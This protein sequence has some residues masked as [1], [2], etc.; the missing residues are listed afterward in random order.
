MYFQKSNESVSFEVI[1]YLSVM[2]VQENE[3]IKEDQRDRQ[4]TVWN[5]SVH[6]HTCTFAQWHSQ[7]NI[8][9]AS[10]FYQLTHTKSH[11]LI[12][13]GTLKKTSL[14]LVVLSTCQKYLNTSDKSPMYKAIYRF[15]R[16]G[17]I[18]LLMRAASIARAIWRRLGPGLFG[19]CE[20][21]SSR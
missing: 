3:V 12:I 13:W 7:P 8:L 20:M 15:I 4:S 21:A 16:L 18:M 5:C 11:L 19:S 10:S 9:P 1:I 17:S 6:S 14:L 2:I